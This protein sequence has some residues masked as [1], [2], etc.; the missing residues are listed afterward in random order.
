MRGVAWTGSGAVTT[1]EVSD[2]NGRTWAAARLLGK[3]QPYTWREWTYQW[4]PKRPGEAVLLSRATDSTGSTQPLEQV[5][6]A[7]GY[8]NNG[9]IPRRVVVHPG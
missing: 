9:V 6:N 7:L 3:P 4:S 1:V 8:C 2:D 5:W